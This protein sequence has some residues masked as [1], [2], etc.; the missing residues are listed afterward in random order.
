MSETPPPPIDHHQDEPGAAEPKINQW[1]RQLTKSGASDLHLKSNSAPR[2]RIDGDVRAIN[3]AK[4]SDKQIHELVSEIMTPEQEAYF[5]KHGAVDLAHQ[6]PDG[7]RFRINIYR[8]R[9]LTSVA[10]RRV[11]KDIPGFISL[12]L[13]SVIEKLSNLR[14]GLVLVAGVTGSGKSTTIASM[15]NH[16]NHTRACHI[17]TI[18]DPIE[19]LY[20][21]DKAFV[22]QREIGID[23][24][25]FSAALKYL[26]REDPYVVLIGELRDKETFEAALHA[27]ETGHLVFGTVHASTAIGTIGRVLDLFSETSRDQ[28]RQSLTTSLQAIIVLKLLPSIDPS[29]SRIPAVE[30]LIVNAAARKMI[31]EGREDELMEVIRSD[32]QG[33]MQDFNQALHAL[34]EGEKI[35]LK[36]ALANSP[37]PNELQMRLKGIRTSGG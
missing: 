12:N 33:G 1:F 29:I 11:S 6:V 21:D 20:T 30:V 25:T 3:S 37:N 23:V 18:E 24:A 36:E 7:D 34:V 16:I 5:R 14:Q 26:M 15:L 31:E 9:G 13:P 27:S 17:V 10:A 35:S 22:N 4:L 32:Q 19:F 8:Q 28:V 2:V